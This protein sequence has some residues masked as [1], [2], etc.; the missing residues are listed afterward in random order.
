MLCNKVHIVLL[1]AEKYIMEKHR[2]S[3]ETRCFLYLYGQNLMKL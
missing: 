3:F 1:Y 2:I